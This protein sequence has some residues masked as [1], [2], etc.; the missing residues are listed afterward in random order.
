MELQSF[1]NI[2]PILIIS[3]LSLIVLLIEAFYKKSEIIIYWVTIIGSIGTALFSILTMD[4][5]FLNFSGT[6]HSGGITNFFYFIF[7]L[8]VGLVTIVTKNYLLKINFHHGEF[9]ILLLFSALGMMIM[10]ASRDLMLTFL[11]LELMSVCFY[12]LAGFNRKKLLNNEASL[13]YFLLGAFATGILLYGIA[14]IYGSAKTTNITTIVGSF[15]AL[16]SNIVFDVG[17]LMLLIGFSF[18][19]AAFP[20][21]MWVPDV[22]DGSPTNV[23]AFMSTAGK[24]AAF[25]ALIVSFYGSTIEP[26]SFSNFSALIATLATCSMLFGSIVA[27]AQTNL[28]RMLAYS[29]IAHAGYMLIGLAAANKLGLSGIIFYLTVYTFMNLGAFILVS[30]NEDSADKRVTLDDFAGLGT[31]KP[32]LAALMSIF[33]FGLAG[34]PPFGG[35]FGKYYVFIS[36]IEADLT[37]LAIIGVLSSVIS[38]YF[39]LRVIVYM[40]FREVQITWQS[41]YSFAENFVLSLSVLFILQMGIFPSTILDLI[42]KY[43]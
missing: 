29:S 19:I 34:L 23:T 3:I 20:F 24:T 12:V 22:Y 17:L 28:K 1:Y 36:A 31:Q 9:Y 11:G 8:T 40:Y 26:N 38:A 2:A 39:Y 7:L 37:W 21:H 35:F 13:K 33:M 32:S 14:L 42:T 30:L 6:L 41:K 16:L 18:K 5:Q 27:L 4:A 10:A 25:S 43:L 15:P